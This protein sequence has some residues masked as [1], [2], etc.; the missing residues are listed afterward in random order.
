MCLFS[1]FCLVLRQQR[2]SSRAKFRLCEHRVVWQPRSLVAFPPPKKAILLVQKRA[3]AAERRRKPCRLTRQGKEAR[4]H[5]STHQR[6]ME[7]LGFLPDAD[8]FL[9]HLLCLT[10]DRSQAL[11]QD[12]DLPSSHR[13]CVCVCVWTQPAV[14][15]AHALSLAQQTT[16]A[17]RSAKQTRR[18]LR[19]SQ[20]SSV[21][22]NS[23][24][25][26]TPRCSIH[27]TPIPASSKQQASN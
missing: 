19:D 3:S 23:T 4:S 26:H 7:M 9:L 12:G 5:T 2:A 17:T 8:P 14:C 11:Q 18:L 20:S 15:E 22:R 6:K 25:P 13:V 16:N 10:V 24:L 27:N 21:Q 1:P